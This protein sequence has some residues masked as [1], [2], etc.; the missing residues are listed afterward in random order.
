MQLFIIFIALSGAIRQIKKNFVTCI[1]L[2]FMFSLYLLNKVYMTCA[3]YVL[4]LI[5]ILSRYFATNV[6]KIDVETKVSAFT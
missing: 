3:R 2:V 4:L 1:E 6:G 5:S